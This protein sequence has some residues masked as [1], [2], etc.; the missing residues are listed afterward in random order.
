MTKRCVNCYPPHSVCILLIMSHWDFWTLPLTLNTACEDNQAS[1]FKRGCSRQWSGSRNIC[2]FRWTFLA[3]LLMNMHAEGWRSLGE[4]SA[5]WPFLDLTMFSI[6]LQ[7]VRHAP[8]PSSAVSLVL[9]VNG[10]ADFQQCLEV[11][12]SRQLD[13][14]LWKSAFISTSRY[15]CTSGETDHW[16]KIDGHF[17]HL[18]CF[19]G[20]MKI[21]GSLRL[22]IWPSVLIISLF[23]KWMSHP[24]VCV[25]L[26]LQNML[27]KTHLACTVAK[28]SFPCEVLVKV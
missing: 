25:S 22:K 26:M 28:L 7:V 6:S 24:C 23:T 15:R 10:F 13:L 16:S 11:P 3:I 5:K 18:T 2:S 19:P 8:L 21:G 17:Q 20:W 1:V 27:W 14:D 4:E 9:D 12:T